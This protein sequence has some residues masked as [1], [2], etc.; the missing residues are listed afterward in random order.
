MSL[1]VRRISTPCFQHDG[2][3]PTLVRWLRDSDLYLPDTWDDPSPLVGDIVGAQYTLP[4]PAPQGAPAWASFT[5]FRCYKSFQRKSIRTGIWQTFTGT[6]KRPA[7][8]RS[9]THRG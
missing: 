3:G 7:F 4:H 9:T 2:R 1:R 6:H 5:A 8:G